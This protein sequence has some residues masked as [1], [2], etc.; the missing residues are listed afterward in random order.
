MHS[1]GGVYGGRL[2]S[3]RRMI[4]VHTE[5]HWNTYGGRC[6]FIWREVIVFY[7][8]SLPPE[9]VERMIEQ[10]R[11]LPAGGRELSEYLIRFYTKED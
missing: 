10:A 6:D 1:A 9:S 2:D 4:R 7:M 8:M 5:G 11:R 3:I